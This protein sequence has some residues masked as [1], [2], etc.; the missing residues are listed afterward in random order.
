MN[1]RQQILLNRRNRLIRLKVKY[2]N[3]YFNVQVM[4]KNISKI[5]KC[6]KLIKQLL[7]GTK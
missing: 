7:S 4:A 1:D 2:T 3:E 6:D 5:E